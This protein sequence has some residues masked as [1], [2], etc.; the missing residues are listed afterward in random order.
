[1]EGLP[2]KY[3]AI[4]LVAAI[5]IVAVY[6]VASTFTGQAS[7]GGSQLSNVVGGGVNATG[8]D[9]CAKLGGEWFMAKAPSPNVGKYACVYS[10]TDC[11]QNGGTWPTGTTT[12]G[13][14]PK[15]T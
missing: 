3:I 8:Q 2:L 12:T 6:S 9:A 10:Q 13:T 11:E 15:C 4:V 5:V 7:Q 14:N 1:M